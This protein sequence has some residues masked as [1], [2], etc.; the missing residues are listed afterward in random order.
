MSLLKDDEYISKRGIYAT[1]PQSLRARA[2]KLRRW[3]SSRDEKEVVLT[4][5]GKFWAY[6]VGE[7]DKEGNQTGECATSH[8]CLEEAVLKKCWLMLTRPILDQ[9]V[10]AVFHMC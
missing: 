5:H 2:R 4:G 3:V 10:L 6:V 7:M 9:P 8:S 1:D